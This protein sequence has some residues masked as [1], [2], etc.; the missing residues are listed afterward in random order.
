MGS[1][2]VGL[3]TQF[4]LTQSFFGAAET[5][6]LARGLFDSHT[7]NSFTDLQDNAKVWAW[8]QT[9]VCNGLEISYEFLVFSFELKD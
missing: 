6:L 1:V 2:E 3:E 8:L 9:I 5:K 4:F 7:Q